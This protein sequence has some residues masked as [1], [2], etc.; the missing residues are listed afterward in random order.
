MLK[1][2]CKHGKY[3]KRHAVLYR[4]TLNTILTKLLTNSEL[5]T[6]NNIDIKLIEILKCQL[7][8]HKT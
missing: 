6:H 3:N 1:E 4:T 8:R 5:W 7:L 2:K